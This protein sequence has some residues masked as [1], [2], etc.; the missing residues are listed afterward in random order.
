M[1]RSSKNTLKIIAIC[2]A[3]SLALGFVGW[4]TNGFTAFDKDSISD[5]FER[6]LNEDNLVYK[7]FLASGY[8]SKSGNDGNGLTWTIND[9]GSVTVNGT[10]SADAY[11]NLC[12]VTIADKGD[13]T[14]TAVDGGS[15]TTYYVEGKA[16][17]VTVW[18]S[19]W[20]N[21]QDTSATKTFSTSTTISLDIVIKAGTE[22]K[23]V[24]F[25]PVIVEG[26]T[27]GNYFA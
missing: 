8:T 3:M 5:K 10:A 25:Y 12:T 6:K 14:F 22:M 18:Y 23:N 19:D 1:S 15:L 9:D 17:G 27:A 7:A 4:M 26:E 20:Q 21:I 11:F 13:Q 24:T 2:L 16:N